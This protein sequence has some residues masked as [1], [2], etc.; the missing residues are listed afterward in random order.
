MCLD[1]VDWKLVFDI[2]FKKDE[3]ELFERFKGQILEEALVYCH[4]HVLEEPKHKWNRDNLVLK[5]FVF[6]EEFHLLI[7]FDRCL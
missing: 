4:E 3:Q 1:Y 2:F 5:D 6:K 7:F